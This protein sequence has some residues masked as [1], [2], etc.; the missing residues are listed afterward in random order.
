MN[1]FK[2]FVQLKSHVFNSNYLLTNYLTNE[3]TQLISKCW[4]KSVYFWHYVQYNSNESG[5]SNIHKE[6]D[7][8]RMGE[9]AT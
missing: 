5:T 7:T 8:S 3:Q 2:M 6:I 1:V 4:I 9:S